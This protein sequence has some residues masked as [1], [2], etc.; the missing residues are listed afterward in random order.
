MPPLNQSLWTLLITSLTAFWAGA[1]CTSQRWS[2]ASA[3]R[4]S[5]NAA[6][7]LTRIALGAEAQQDS[8]RAKERMGE[9]KRGDL[10]ASRARSGLKRAS[11]GHVPAPSN[12]DHVPNGLGLG[13]CWEAIKAENA[14]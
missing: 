8:G 2:N 4:A 10:I 13:R 11:A 5:L 12:A 9:A 3:G 1:S 7:Q 6:S 14:L